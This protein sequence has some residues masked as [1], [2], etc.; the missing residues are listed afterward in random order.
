MSFGRDFFDSLSF[1][2]LF[3]EVF[4]QLGG[5]LFSAALLHKLRLAIAAQSKLVFAPGQLGV[6]GVNGSFPGDSRSI[7]LFAA[8]NFT[9]TPSSS[10]FR[11]AAPIAGGDG[12][13]GYSACNTANIFAFYVPIHKTAGGDLCPRCES[14]NAASGHAAFHIC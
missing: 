9:L 8:D 11:A 5:S 7:H 4:Q 2:F 13:S 3:F 1:R 6:H 14:C 12:A 10:L